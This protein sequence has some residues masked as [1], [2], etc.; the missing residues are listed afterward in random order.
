MTFASAEV[1]WNEVLNEY[2]LSEPEDLVSPLPR[3]ERDGERQLLPPSVA[4]REP[5]PELAGG[6]RS[7]APDPAPARSTARC[8]ATSSS[9][10]TAS[11]STAPTPATTTSRKTPLDRRPP[12]SERAEQGQRRRCP[13]RRASRP[14]NNNHAHGNLVGYIDK[15]GTYINAPILAP[16]DGA[17]EG[18]T[19]EA[20]LNTIMAQGD[21]NAAAEAAEWTFWQAKLATKRHHD[22][23]IGAVPDFRGRGLRHH[24]HDRHRH[25]LQDRLHSRESAPRPLMTRARPRIGRSPSSRPV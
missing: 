5:D 13:A 18:G 17:P 3:L 10:G 7:T 1:S 2:D 22:R 8:S 12:A 4:D 6:S 21:I 14:G 23:S 20:G 16:P 15:D 25:R 9:M 19:T 11:S 24:R